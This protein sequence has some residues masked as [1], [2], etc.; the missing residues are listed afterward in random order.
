MA[1]RIIVGLTGVLPKMNLIWESHFEKKV[2]RIRYGFII[3]YSITKS[4]KNSRTW[5]P[6]PIKVADN[7]SSNKIPCQIFF[8]Y[9]QWKSRWLAD[10][11]D[12]KQVGYN[13]EE[14]Q[15]GKVQRKK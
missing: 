2:I 11:F 14:D 1:S 15:L 6:L 4:L 8:F 12:F 9:E 5:E 3:S 7:R 10:S 13:N